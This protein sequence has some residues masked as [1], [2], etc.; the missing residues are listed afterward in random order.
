MISSVRSKGWLPAVLFAALAVLSKTPC[1]TADLLVSSSATHEVLAYDEISGASQ[2]VFV[3]ALSGGLTNPWGLTYGPDGNLYVG[4]RGNGAV[5]RYNGTTGAFIDAFVAPSGGLFPSDVVFGPDGNLYVGNAIL[6]G[7]LVMRYNGTTGASL[8]AFVTSG[9]G[10]IGA[11]DG[12]TF[13]PDNN[14][15]LVGR[16][17]GGAPH[18]GVLRYNGTT[19]AFMSAFVPSGSGGL[20]TP[21][22]LRFAPDGNLDVSSFVSDQVLRYNGTTGAPLGSATIGGG[23]DGPEGLAFGPDG[24]LYVADFTPDNVLRYNA[25]TA[26]FMGIFASGSGLDAPARLVFQ[27]GGGGPGSFDYGDAPDGLLGCEGSIANDPPPSLYP[28]IL[29][30]LNAAPGR[31]EPFHIDL[32]EVVLGAGVTAEAGAFQASCDWIKAGCDADDA[33]IILLLGP[34][35]GGPFLSGVVITAGG[36]CVERALGV[37]GPYPGNPCFGIWIFNA[38]TSPSALPAGSYL[39]NVAVDWNLSGDFGDVAGEWPLVDAPV[40]IGPSGVTTM[41]TPPFL[42]TTCFISGASWAIQ[43]FWTRF[44][45]AEEAIGPLFPGSDWDGSGPPPGNRVGETEDWVPF[46]DPP[47][48]PP[49]CRINA[50]LDFYTTPSGGGTNADFGATPIP[51]GFFGPGS[52]PFTGNV[53]LGGSPLSTSPPGL[54]DPVNTIVRRLATVDLSGPGDIETIPIELVALSLTSVNPITVTYNGGQN[55]ELW[56]VGVS[57][58]QSQPEPVGTLTATAGPCGGVGGTFDAT[59]PVLPRFTF[60]RLNDGMVGVFDYG[61]QGLPP[62]VFGTAI[63]PWTEFNSADGNMDAAPDECDLVEFYRS[64]SGDLRV[65]HDADPVSPKIVLPEGTTNFFPGT[66]MY[67]CVANSCSEGQHFRFRALPYHGPNNNNTVLIP[68]FHQRLH[69]ASGLVA[70]KGPDTDG[71]GIDDFVDNCPLFPNPRQQDQDHDGVGDICDNCNTPNGYNPCQE[72]GDNDGIGDRCEVTDASL[73]S[74]VP[75]R[76]MLGIP[77]PNPARDILRYTVMLPRPGRARVLVFDGSGRV[78]GNLFDSWLP[79]GNHPLE[80]DGVGRTRLK[81]G[82]YYLSLDVGSVRETRKFCVVR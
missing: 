80:W 3:S 44:T 7:T 68:A 76:V 43:P 45:V 18:N 63:E 51:A 69:A 24:N 66:Q 60:T 78:V 9:S 14:L 40:P 64:F 41:A 67:G 77:R 72:D 71:D 30:T 11:C 28:T 10:G 4:S 8:G 22:A 2:G 82:V 27:P 26:A 56:R 73:A 33:P 12:F 65:D 57:V 1:A 6:G 74:T 31:R 39:A 34:T 5:L 15:Y 20:S 19:G 52:D 48:G 79:A 13:G 47:T 36:A 58:S 32:S 49:S 16:T 55:P 42:V 53:I 62:I 37:F 35:A 61:T 25:S 17:V 38:A 29:G 50:G 46:G 81:S 59:L 75:A 21:R 70:A 23:L 54:I